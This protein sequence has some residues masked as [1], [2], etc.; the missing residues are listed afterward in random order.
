LQGIEEGERAR[1]EADDQEHVGEP[2][3]RNGRDADD[4]IAPA[5]GEA[6]GEKC[7]EQT[8]TAGIVGHRRRE[9]AA[10]GGDHDEDR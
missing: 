4:Q 5:R 9:L 8:G 10:H 1:G 2:G 7:T 6:V 3:E